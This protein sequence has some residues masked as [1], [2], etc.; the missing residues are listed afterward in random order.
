M[1]QPHRGASTRSSWS[2]GAAD[3]SFCLVL[4]PLCCSSSST[5]SDRRG[6]GECDTFQ[7]QLGSQRPQ[8]P[9]PTYSATLS[10]PYYQKE[11]QPHS[12]YMLQAPT[13]PG[14]WAACCS[15]G[16]RAAMSTMLNSARN[17][18]L[19]S[20]YACQR[21]GCMIMLL[22]SRHAALSPQNQQQHSASASARWLLSASCLPRRLEHAVQQSAPVAPPAT[23]L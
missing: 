8:R 9:A 13:Q 19:S 11:L 21:R 22:S 18:V 4:T 2:V 5:A 10:T 6:S 14:C 17:M 16:P 3:E 23:G 7:V 20:R 12:V 1:I 15:C